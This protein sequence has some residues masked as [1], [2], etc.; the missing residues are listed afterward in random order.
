MAVPVRTAATARKPTA[1]PDQFTAC[2][3][4]LAARSVFHERH[5]Y[6]LRGAFLHSLLALCAF[7]SVAVKPGLT[8]FTVMP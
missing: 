3:Q 1:L 5:A 7:K 4:E 6:D 8:E 2:F